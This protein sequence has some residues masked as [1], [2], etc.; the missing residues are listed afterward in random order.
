VWGFDFTEEAG[1]FAY[2]GV[3]EPDELVAIIDGFLSEPE[4]LFGGIIAQL[5]ELQTVI[6]ETIAPAYHAGQEAAVEYCAEVGLNEPGSAEKLGDQDR[7]I[8]EAWKRVPHEFGPSAAS[9]FVEGFCRM[10]GYEWL[11]AVSK[12]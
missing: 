11:N 12:R 4:H 3:Q 2:V 5:E 1:P 7:V 8:A 6:R 10:F 9:W